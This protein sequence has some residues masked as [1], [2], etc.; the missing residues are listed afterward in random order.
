M[1]FGFERRAR[2]YNFD[3]SIGA[4]VEEVALVST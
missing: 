1:A 2:K 4:N 3:H